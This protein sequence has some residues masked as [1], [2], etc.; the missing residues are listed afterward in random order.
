MLPEQSITNT[1]SVAVRTRF[2]F[3]VGGVS[4]LI[5]GIGHIDDD[6]ARC[7]LTDNLAAAQLETPLDEKEMAAV[8]KRVSAA[9]KD[10]ANAYFQ[11]PSIGLTPPRNVGIEAD[12]S[13]PAFGRKAVRVSWDTAYAGDRVIDHYVVLRDGQEIA[14]VPHHPQVGP[15]R[16][17]Y[18]D[19]SVG[20]QATGPHRYCIR[21]VDI[22]GNRADSESLTTTL[23]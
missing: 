21:T 7:Q 15:N 8:E 23:V 13:M 18:D 2:S 22:A 6:P 17:Y 4:T 19:P 11:R 9:G 14:R 1:C 16:F 3:S 12:S 10:G 20:D 5:I